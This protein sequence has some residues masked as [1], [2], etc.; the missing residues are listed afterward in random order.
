MQV[1]KMACGNFVNLIKKRAEPR[2]NY[3]LFVLLV[4]E[5]CAP[6]WMQI[7]ILGGVNRWRRFLYAAWHGEWGD[8]IGDAR[9]E[10]VG[11]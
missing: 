10:R 9:E 5:S 1:I 3:S 8:A 2:R 6:F 4:P 11:D 7:A